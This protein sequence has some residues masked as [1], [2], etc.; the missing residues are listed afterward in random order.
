[1]A[2][3]ASSAPFQITPRKVS[4]DWSHSTPLVWVTED[5][6]SSHWGNAFHYL[7]TQGE[8][9]FCRTFREALPH[10][11]DPKLREDVEAFIAQ[12]AIHS[13]AHHHAIQH[14]HKPLHIEGGRF[15]KQNEWLFDGLL[16]AKPFGKNLP[17]QFHHQWLVIRV[18]TVAAIEHFTA[19]LGAYLLEDVRWEQFGADPI[20]ADLYRWH[21]AEEVEHR[22]VA[23]DLYRHLGGRWPLRVLLMTAVFPILLERQASGIMAM[24]RYE[25]ARKNQKPLH[26]LRSWKQSSARKTV[27]SA[28][29]F[30]SKMLRFMSPRYNPLQEASTELALAYIANSAAVKR[31]AANQPA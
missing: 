18:G 24:D 7:L 23:Y 29:W 31:A 8:K 20:I 3:A 14:V 15:E 4:F 10:I 27:P 25:A 16:A 30:M 1:M 26:F 17:P 11:S 22:T 9:F 6:F 21:G 5:A 13:A 2:T 19:A 12:E 28:R